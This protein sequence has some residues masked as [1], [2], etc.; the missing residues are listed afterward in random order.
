MQ[1]ALTLLAE[2]DQDAERDKMHGKV[3]VEVVYQHGA[4]DRVRAVKEATYK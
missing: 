1:R 3:L 4:I 2:M